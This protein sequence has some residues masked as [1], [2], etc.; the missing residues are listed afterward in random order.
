MKSE[1]AEGV[2]L[3]SLAINIQ[4]DHFTSSFPGSS[5]FL[6]RESPLVAA[7]HPCIQIK[8]AL[9]VGHP[10]NFIISKVQLYLK[11]EKPDCFSLPN[12]AH[13]LSRLQ[14]LF[15]LLLLLFILFFFAT[16][17]N[18]YPPAQRTYIY[19]FSLF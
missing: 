8:S 14:F 16:D 15:Y 18:G 19:I 5:L 9:M 1:N 11:K 2:F 10:L 4:I 12:G 13:V 7:A 6:A 17:A 3:D